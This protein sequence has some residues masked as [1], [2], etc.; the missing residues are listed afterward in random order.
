MVNPKMEMSDEIWDFKKEK[1]ISREDFNG[2]TNKSLRSAHT[3]RKVGKDFADFIGNKESLLL[4]WPSV[5]E[6]SILDIEYNRHGMQ[7]P[8]DY[9]D[10]LCLYTMAKLFFMRTN[11]KVI[12]P[13][14]EDDPI[15]SLKN[16]CYT[17]GIEQVEPSHRALPDALT[18]YILYK[19]MIN[20][21]APE[22]KSK[23]ITHAD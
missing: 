11:S 7:I 22:K 18:E 15:F 21:F 16:V 17:L 20:T 23:I 5:F 10:W 3:F 6:N 12:S 4:S 19:G 13:D 1:Y 9:K 8:Y 14:G 2:I